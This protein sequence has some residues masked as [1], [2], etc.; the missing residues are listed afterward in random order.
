MTKSMIAK[1]EEKKSLE[2]VMTQNS[3]LRA[4]IMYIPA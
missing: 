1:E 2:K 4:Q 3:N